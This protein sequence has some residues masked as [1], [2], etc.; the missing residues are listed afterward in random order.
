MPARMPTRDATRTADPSS[1]ARARASKDHAPGACFRHHFHFH[2]HCYEPSPSEFLLLREEGLLWTTRLITTA[3]R[4][5]SPDDR[6]G[7]QGNADIA[8]ILAV[9]TDEPAGRSDIGT[10]LIQA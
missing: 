8:A 6:S 7:P 3:M 1:R 4:R 9:L 2:C 10:Q 5:A